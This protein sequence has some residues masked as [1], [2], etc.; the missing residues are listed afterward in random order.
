MFGETRTGG[1]QSPDE[2]SNH[3]Y[4]LELLAVFLALKS[5]PPQVTGK[6]VKGMVNNMTAISDINNMETSEC[7]NRNQLV[8]DLY[9][10]LW[11]VERNVW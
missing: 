1:S 9:M 4:Y 5:F 2:M 3:I 7:K 11:C 10:W 6:H 8:K